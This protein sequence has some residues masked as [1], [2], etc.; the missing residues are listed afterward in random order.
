MLSVERCREILGVNEEMSDEEFE[1]LQEI[2][3]NFVSSVIENEI[4]EDLL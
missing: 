4:I 2:L 3:R 1:K